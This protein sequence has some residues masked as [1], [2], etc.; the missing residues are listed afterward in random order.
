MFETAVSRLTSKPETLVKAKPLY[1]FIHDFESRYGELAQIT[2]LETRMNQ[3]FPEDPMLA[4]FSRRFKNHDFDPTAIRPVISPATQTRAKAISNT[5]HPPTTNGL[6]P[7]NPPPSSPKRS[8]APDDSDAD[9]WRPHKVARVE[10]PLKGAAGRRLDQQKRQQPTQ[11]Q[12]R[13]ENQQVSQNNAAPSLPRDILFLLSIIPSADTYSMAKFKP[14]AMIKLIRE[15]NLPNTVSSFRYPQP[16]TGSQQMPP[17]SQPPQMHMQQTQQRS[18][19][20]I[21]QIAPGSHMQQ[22]QHMPQTQQLQ[23]PQQLPQSHQMQQMP[24][25]APGQQIPMQQYSPTPQGQYPSKIPIFHYVIF[26]HALIL[27]SSRMYKLYTMVLRRMNRLSWKVIVADDS[28]FYS[29]DGLRIF[30]SFKNSRCA[31][32][33]EH[34]G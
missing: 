19:T 32:L 27:L 16:P 5:Q 33:S 24:H 13:L 30:T 4:V 15:T 12:V 17:M 31:S 23:K 25:L 6:T 28:E 26:N 34:D 18:A 29:D 22:L 1:A 9:G 21:P 14:E 20:S 11:E 2:K 3:L 7:K 10:S 8:L